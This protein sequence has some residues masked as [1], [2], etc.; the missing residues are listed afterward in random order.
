[1]KRTLAVCLLVFLSMSALVPAQAATTGSD[2]FDR[3]RAK[4]KAGKYRSAFKLLEP[5]AEQGNADAQLYLGRMY[6]SGRLA[7]LDGAE[8]AHWFRKAADQGNPEAQYSL[9]RL[10]LAGWGVP[11]NAKTALAW[12]WKSGRQDYLKA[13]LLLGQLLS[14][15]KR[16][17]RDLGAARLWYS[18]AASLGSAEAAGKLEA[19]GSAADDAAGGDAP[20][21]PVVPDV[22]EIAAADRSREQLMKRRLSELRTMQRNE[23]EGMGGAMDDSIEPHGDDEDTE[24]DSEKTLVVDKVE[25]EAKQEPV[26]EQGP[27]KVEPSRE[28]GVEEFVLDDGEGLEELVLEEFDSSLSLEDARDEGT[29]GDFDAEAG[30]EDFL[31]VDESESEATEEPVTPKAKVEPALVA[32]AAKPKPEVVV[33]APA[34]V[35]KPAVAPVAAVAVLSVPKPAAKPAAKPEPTARPKSESVAE[36]VAEQA[37]ADAMGLYGRDWVLARKPNHYTIQ[38][39]GSRTRK[40]AETFVKKNSLTEPAAVV[41]SRRRGKQWFSLFYG[42]YRSYSKAKAGL[43][44]LSKG[45]ARHGPWI[46]KYKKIQRSLGGKR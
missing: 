42:D 21:A 3:G 39:L 33:V 32:G 45:L 23:R 15:G 19:M 43:K 18:Q 24:D 36:P 22:A 10:Y 40:E 14:E 2:A 16:V 6:A 20:A 31:L 11:A 46:R 34:P 25:P 5:F 35:A 9:G 17:P 8:A 4:F 26:V 30:S 13:Q 38:L 12:L 44:T 41:E 37:K 1:V 7:E 28:E 29:G 27:A